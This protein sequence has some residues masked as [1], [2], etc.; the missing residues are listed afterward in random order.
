M[1]ASFLH[2]LLIEVV[3]LGNCLTSLKGRNSIAYGNAIGERSASL[4]SPERAIV[5]S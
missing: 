1:Q 5:L 3:F 2:S 4:I